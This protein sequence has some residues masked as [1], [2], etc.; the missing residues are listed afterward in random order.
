VER[1]VMTKLFWSHDPVMTSVHPTEQ[2]VKDLRATVK[3]TLEE[4]VKPLDTYLKT[5]DGFLEFLQLDVEA[6]VKDAEEK[7]GGPPPGLTEDELQELNAPD[8]DVPKLREMAEDHFAKKRE[9]GVLIP[10]KAR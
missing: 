3:A 10:E 5:F 4:A 8:L 1:R 2:W 7:Y 9:I 6:Y